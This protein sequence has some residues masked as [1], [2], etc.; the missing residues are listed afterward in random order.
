FGQEKNYQKS[1]EILERLVRI[2]RGEHE[3]FRLLAE[4]YLA[5]GEHEKAARYFN[6]GKEVLIKTSFEGHTAAETLYYYAYMLGDTH[7]R[8]KN[9]RVAV[10]MF[11]AA[12]KFARTEKDKSD[13]ENYVKWINW[14]S[15]NI[16]ASEKWDEIIALENVKDYKKMA[17]VCEKLLPELQTIEARLSVHQKLAVVEFEFLDRKGQAVERMKKVFEALSPLQLQN[18]DERTI[19]ILNTY[20]A[21][22]YRLGVDARNRDERKIALAYFSKASAF[23]WDQMAKALMEMVSLVW[24]T[25]RQAVNYGEKALQLGENVLTATEKCELLSL[26][27]KA[28]KSAGQFEKARTYFNTWKKCQEKKT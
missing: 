17:S 9:A 26:M 11:K 23:K 18:P 7:A 24:N 2:E 4:N 25:P 20:G 13:V 3:L 28:H 12:L 19:P 8:M 14:D 22:L 1:V 16:S 6:I 15:G 5:M 27:V 21:M 10:N